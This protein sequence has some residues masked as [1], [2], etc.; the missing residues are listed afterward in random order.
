M[1][2]PPGTPEGEKGAVP[3]PP[4]RGHRQRA[5]KPAQV[6]T[7][8]ARMSPG[9]GPR[10]PPTTGGSGREVTC[11]GPSVLPAARGRA[12]ACDPGRGPQD[13]PRV[14]GAGHQVHEQ[15]FMNTEL[16]THSAHGRVRGL[17][18][19]SLRSEPQGQGVGLVLSQGPTFQ[20]GAWPT[21]TWPHGA[22]SRQSPSQGGGPRPSRLVWAP[23]SWRPRALGPAVPMPA[24]STLA[25]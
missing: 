15:G 9:E 25:E 2:A 11:P 24:Q 18:G 4:A 13:G 10:S 16:L 17:P 21:K 8:R 5:S 3:P 12:S 1:T 23:P 20:P 7:S 6:H 14:E 22:S 19:C